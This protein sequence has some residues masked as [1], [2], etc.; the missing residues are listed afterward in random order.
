M[1]PAIT[2]TLLALC[3]G[4]LGGGIWVEGR[5]DGVRFASLRRYGLPA[6]IL[7]VV[8]AYAVLRPG[9]GDNGRQALAASASANMPLLV[10]IYSNW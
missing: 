10:D 8:L 3:A 2:Y 5:K 1:H 9:H 7:A 4:L 6:Q